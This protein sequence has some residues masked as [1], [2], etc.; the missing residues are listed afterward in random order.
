MAKRNRGGAPAVGANGSPSEVEK[1]Q[2]KAA[3]KRAAK[4]AKPAAP[5]VRDLNEI[6]LFTARAIL[7]EKQVLDERKKVFQLQDQLLK[8]QTANL[9]LRAATH[10]AEVG[11]KDKE[12]NDFLK[13][14]GVEDG[15]KA[16]LEDGRLVIT[17]GAGKKQ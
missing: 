14:L 16:D 10:N 12:R 11:A 17:R 8:A 13:T 4:A 5:D 2:K 3:A 6:E 1:I 15:D 9:Q 7:A